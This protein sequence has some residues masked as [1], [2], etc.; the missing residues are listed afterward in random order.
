M[1]VPVVSVKYNKKGQGTGYTDKGTCVYID[2]KMLGKIDPGKGYQA[3]QNK[4]SQF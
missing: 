1:P 3:G 2:E 4:G